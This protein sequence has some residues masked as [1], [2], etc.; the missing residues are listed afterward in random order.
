MANIVF[1]DS[2]IWVFFIFLLKSVIKIFF[3]CL[4]FY[5]KNSSIVNSDQPDFS[6]CFEDCILS[7]VPCAYFIILISFWIKNIY[8]K[9]KNT[10]FK[11]S[12]LA[13]T[14]TVKFCFK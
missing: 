9:N 5:S 6:K 13:W 12:W 4:F 8:V 2:S 11:Y 3:E 1:C 14:K 10:N 7:L